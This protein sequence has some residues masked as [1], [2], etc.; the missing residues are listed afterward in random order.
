M[1][2]IKVLHFDLYMTVKRHKAIEDK[3]TISF[4]FE[5]SMLR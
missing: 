2:V 4:L 3:V 5:L 1:T